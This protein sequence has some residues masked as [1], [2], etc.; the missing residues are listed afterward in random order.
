MVTQQEEIT[1]LMSRNYTL[2]L[3]D[4]TIVEAEAA[5]QVSIIQ[6][7]AEGKRLLG[8]VAIKLFRRTISRLCNYS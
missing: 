5:R 1:E 2:V 4:T 3:A 6:A 7:K 8:L